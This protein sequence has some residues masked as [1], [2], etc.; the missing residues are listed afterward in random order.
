[1]SLATH[2]AVD[3]HTH[4]PAAVAAAKRRMRRSLTVLGIR[5][6]TIRVHW[7][8]VDPDKPG[9]APAKKRRWVVVT[10]VVR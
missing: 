10:A 1:M 3:R 4:G 6:S 2:V 8:D 7:T 9:S 5:P